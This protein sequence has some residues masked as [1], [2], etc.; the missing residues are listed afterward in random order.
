MVAA[1]VRAGLG[2]AAAAIVGG[3][4]LFALLR[5]R[6]PSANADGASVRDRT[7]A[8][9]DPA[10]IDP[11]A[12]MKAEPAT[13]ATAEDV[14]ANARLPSSLEGTRPDGDLQTGGAGHLVV[15]SRTKRFFDYFFVASG[16]ETSAAIRRRVEGSAR[17]HVGALALSEAL[18]LFDRYVRFRDDARSVVAP[19][20]ATNA[21]YEARVFALRALRRR[22]FGEADATAFFA[23]DE[24]LEDAQRI[25]AQIAA[26][27]NASPAPASPPLAESPAQ[28]VAQDATWRAL[29]KDARNHARTE[30]LGAESAARL[31]TLDAEDDAWTAKVAKY[32]SSRDAF[33]S[34]DGGDVSANDLE[35]LRARIF[36]PEERIRIEALDRIEAAS[37]RH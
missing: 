26:S 6:V 33:A 30:S 17:G 19:M 34:A 29:P 32:R 12:N 1:R 8:A 24:Q 28:L 3:T 10:K 25:H 37:H 18:M 31:A 9:V 7:G 4:A 20:Q 2:A 27:S 35:L 14:S 23:D 11:P 5:S 22:V 13:A 36:A 16:Q 21:D 15:S